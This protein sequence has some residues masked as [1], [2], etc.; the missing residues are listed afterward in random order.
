[1]YTGELQAPS[2]GTDLQSWDP[3][4]NPVVDEVG[5]L[6]VTNPMP[7]M[8]IHFWNDPDGS[9]YHDSYFDTYPG[10]WRHG[11]WITVT[12]RGSVVIHGRSD[13]TL[14][15]Q[16]VRMG[17]A[18]IYEVVE[19]LPEIRESLVIGLEQPDGGY[20]MPLFVVLAEGAVLDGAL[21]SR[22]R[23]ALRQQ[24]SPRHV[25][26]EII[27]VPALPHTLTGKRIEVPV[28]RLLSGTP[29]EQAV[30][31]GSVDN[32]DALRAFTRLAAERSAR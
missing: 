20:W 27:A 22:I 32:L 30:N 31:P 16:G 26:D 10:V 13:S 7:S 25:P 4:G 17:S 5:E 28:K 24:L 6:V 2:L 18:D 14:N 29:L 21:D 15:R 9:R 11:D 23:G 8:P 3:A 19:R 12:S 1:V